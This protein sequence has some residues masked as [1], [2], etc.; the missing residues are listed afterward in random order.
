MTD[1]EL[2]FSDTL[3]HWTKKLLL[4]RSSEIMD[5]YKIE[6]AEQKLGFLSLCTATVLKDK[7]LYPSGS[8]TESRYFNNSVY[9][10]TKHTVFCIDKSFLEKDTSDIMRELS[11]TDKSIQTEQS[12]RRHI[13]KIN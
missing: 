9:E 12:L 3:P 11:L 13:K 1:Y 8:L 5:K 2:E 4:E 6:S 10:Q 7:L